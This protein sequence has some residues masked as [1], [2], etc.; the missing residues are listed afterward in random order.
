MEKRI[1]KSGPGNAMTVEGVHGRVRVTRHRA[2]RDYTPAEARE[3]AEAL[4]AAADDPG[5]VPTWEHD[6]V[7]YDLMRPWGGKFDI[8]IH[9]AWTGEYTPEGVPLMTPHGTE[10]QDLIGSRT[11]FEQLLAQEAR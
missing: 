8:G 11:P 3:L 7:T 1:I 2:Y 4:L 9:W 10:D 5:E 6:G